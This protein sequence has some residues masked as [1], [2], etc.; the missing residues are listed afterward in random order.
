MGIWDKLKGL[1][2][3]TAEKAKEAGQQVAN[4]SGE[5][6]ER[7]GV[8]KVGSAVLEQANKAVDKAAD[9]SESVGGKI[10][11]K[12]NDLLTGAVEGAGKIGDKSGE[13]LEKAGVDKV[14]QTILDKAAAVKDQSGQVAE[15]IG[16]AILGTAAEAGATLKSSAESAMNKVTD[17]VAEAQLAAEAEKAGESSA[18]VQQKT[19]RVELPSDETETKIIKVEGSVSTSD[20]GA[21][22]VEAI[23][24][25]ADQADE[26]SSLDPKTDAKGEEDFFNKAERWAKGDYS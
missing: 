22:E 13:W 3:E 25:K 8:D 11:D 15:K 23:E 24:E 18:P 2:V 19:E 12:T 21:I 1:F 5:I 26:P 14:G 7:A 6:L 10:L 17:F 16:S 9:M 20:D 4:T